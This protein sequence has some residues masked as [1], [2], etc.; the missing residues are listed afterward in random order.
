M[1]SGRVFYPDFV[2][3]VNGRNKE[4]HILLADPKERIHDPKEAVKAAAKHGT[5]GNI[6]VLNLDDQGGARDWYSVRYDESSERAFREGIF[7]LDLMR[8]F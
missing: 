2:V 3:G 7:R 1:S 5:Y 8:T 4:D 6:L